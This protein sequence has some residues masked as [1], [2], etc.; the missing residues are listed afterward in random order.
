MKDKQL[1]DINKIIAKILSKEASLD[2]V[3]DF[4]EWLNENAENKDDFRVLS[5]FWEAGLDS[6]VFSAE[7]SFESNKNRFLPEKSV[8]L[9]DSYISRK[10]YKTFILS[11]AASFLVLFSVGSYWFVQRDSNVQ[12]SYIY[13]SQGDISHF[14]LP[15]SSKV[16]LNKNSKL[17]YSDNFMSKDRKVH[18]EGEAYFDVEK[19]TDKKFIVQVGNSQIE[20]LGTKFNV[21]G[22]NAD[23]YII[24]TLIEGSVLFRNEKQ[25][26]LMMPDQQLTC[27]TQSGLIENTSIDANLNIAWKD[28]LYR[29]NSI[30]LSKL[31]DEL[32]EHY[33]AEIIVTDDLKNIKVSGAFLQYQNIGEVLN[34]MQN[35]I[36]FKWKKKSDKI[37]I[38]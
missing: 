2:E 10:K 30:T 32:T 1:V 26:V 15:D 4:S 9:P 11:I 31:A 8:D 17:S 5:E 36:G 13:L 14:T 18:L 37:I 20:V 12:K 29:Y 25:Q 7:M 22:R 35:S 3:V 34:I 23:E 27:F 33:G 19:M 24:A 6:E 21:N 16:T 38:Y 28:R